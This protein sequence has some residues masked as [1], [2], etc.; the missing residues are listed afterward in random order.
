MLVWQ[1]TLPTDV[2]SPPPKAEESGNGSQKDYSERWPNVGEADFLNLNYPS[3]ISSST[4]FVHLLCPDPECL[5]QLD[6]GLDNLLEL[7]N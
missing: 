4:L 3:S 6:S 1:N 2:I 5:P 7:K